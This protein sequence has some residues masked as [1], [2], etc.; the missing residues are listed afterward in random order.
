MYNLSVKNIIFDPENI[1]LKNNWERVSTGIARP[2]LSMEYSWFKSCAEACHRFSLE[3]KVLEVRDQNTDKVIALIPYKLRKEKLYRYF[4][5]NA[6]YFMQLNYEYGDHY[7]LL[8]APEYYAATIDALALWMKE[9]KIDASYLKNM[10]HDTKF[11]S[12]ISN[13][14]QFPLLA[15][16]CERIPCSYICLPTQL[17]YKD[18]SGGKFKRIMQYKRK[19]EKSFQVSYLRIETH[20]ELSQVLSHFKVMHTARFLKKGTSSSLCSDPV[21]FHFLERLVHNAFDH[22]ILMANY[23]TLNNQIASVEISFLIKA[24]CLPILSHLTKAILN[25]E[26]APYRPLA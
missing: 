20:D 8:I 15:T 9:N 16:I 7:E 6:I 11:R 26:L 3:A 24:D 25:I 13:L 14:G 4:D 17:K 23:I 19:L 22:G 5:V 1:D 18:W 12:L 2:G 21:Q 10:Q